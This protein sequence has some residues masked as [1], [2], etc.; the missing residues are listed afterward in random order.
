MLKLLKSFCLIALIIFSLAACGAAD[1]SR[2]LSD[3]NSSPDGYPVPPDDFYPS[4]DLQQPDVLV[5]YPA[6]E[7]KDESKRFEFTLPI[8]PGMEIVN[9]TGPEN[10]P[11]KIISIS[12][13]GEILGTATIGTNRAFEVDLLRPLN[14]NEAIAIMLADD[15]MSQQFL[16]APN[17]TDI[18]LIGFVLN[19]ATTSQ[20]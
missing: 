5:G 6:V 15:S 18:P 1:P 13:T 11:I 19:M 7:V 8:E 17:A 20:P 4:P 9:G 2:D 16:D 3:S 14:S 12:N 10:V